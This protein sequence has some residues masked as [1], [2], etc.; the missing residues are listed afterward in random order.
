ME[1]LEVENI[2]GSHYILDFFGCDR[3]QLDSM[4]FWQKELPKSAKVAGMEILHDK[5]Y[6]NSTKIS[7]TN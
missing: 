6:K 5:F 4:D 1:N 2:K 7:I 3:E